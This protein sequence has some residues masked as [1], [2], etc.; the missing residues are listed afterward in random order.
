MRRFLDGEDVSEIEFEA[1][2]SGLLELAR[3][4][5]VLELAR[6]FRARVRGERISPAPH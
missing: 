1:Y 4:S 3:M 5:G 6:T 2:M